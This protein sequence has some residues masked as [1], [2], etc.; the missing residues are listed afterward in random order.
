MATQS[1]ILDWEIPRTEEPGE[2]QSMG[3]H[4]VRHDLATEQQQPQWQVG[5]IF[6]CEDLLQGK[7]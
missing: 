4:R 2:L 7:K 6:M 3:S 5:W 1:N